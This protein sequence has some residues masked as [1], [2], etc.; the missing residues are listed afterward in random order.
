MT[1]E[2][3]SA[4]KHGLF[5]VVLVTGFYAAIIHKRMIIAAVIAIVG[6]LLYAVVNRERQ[7]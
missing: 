6:V 7:E 2:N 4:L 5:W 1:P 3:Q